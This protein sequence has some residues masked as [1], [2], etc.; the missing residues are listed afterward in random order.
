[1][2]KESRFDVLSLANNHIM[3][4]GPSGL[5]Q[6]MDAL[7]NAGIFHVGAGRTIQE[8]N[9][10]LLMERAGAK[11]AILA[12]SSV[13][14]R[15]PCYASERQPGAAFLNEKE[16]ISNLGECKSVADIVILLM[17]WGVEEYLFPAP[18]Q[19]MWSKKFARAGPISS[20]GITACSSRNRTDRQFFVA[21]SLGILFDEF[22]WDSITGSGTVEK[23]TPDSHPKIEKD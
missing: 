13:I 2:L 4:Y 17:H 5:Y 16:L 9:A 10:P 22:E 14:V 8:A 21:Y 6:T 12:R 15:S 20:S 18:D 1:M 23:F 3:D 19:R 7:D 11:I